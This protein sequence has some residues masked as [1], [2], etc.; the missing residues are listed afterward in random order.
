MKDY[1]DGAAQ[2]SSYWTTR[3]L[4]SN[5]SAGTLVDAWVGLLNSTPELCVEIKEVVF[6]IE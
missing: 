2:K 5:Y 1:F 3:R 4:P 6:N